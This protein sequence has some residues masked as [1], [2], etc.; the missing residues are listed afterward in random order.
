M[1][2][3]LWFRSWCLL[4]NFTGTWRQN[5]KLVSSPSLLFGCWGA[6]GCLH[7][8]FL[9]QKVWRTNTPN[10]F[11]FWSSAQRGA[12]H[13]FAEHCHHVHSEEG[14][15]A[16][17]TCCVF[18]FFFDVM[19]VFLVCFFGCDVFKRLVSFQGMFEPYMKSFY[20]RST[21]PTHIKTLKVAARFVHRWANKCSE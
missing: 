6:T 7:T 15:A 20:V 1:C 21:D 17:Q 8:F 5:T 19:R 2:C 18:F 9:L 13:R 10:V 12:V 14:K 11:S 16:C 4:L 3:L